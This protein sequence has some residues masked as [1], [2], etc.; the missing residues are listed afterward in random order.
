MRTVSLGDYAKLIR[1]ITFKPTEKCA[2]TAEDAVVCMRTKNVQATLDDSDL[3]AVKRNLIRNEDKILMSGDILVSSA[4][5]WNLVGKCCQVPE[6]HYLCT[7]GGFISILRSTNGELESNYLY[8]WFSSDGVQQTLRSFGNQTTNISNLDHKRTLRLQIPLPPLAE[9]QRIAA[10]LDAADALR[11]KRRE[12]LEQ[13]DALV[14]S[15]FINMFGDPVE[16]TMGWKVSTLPQIST[17]FTDGPFGSNLKSSHY[18]DE[19]IRVIRLQNIGIGEMLHDDLAFISREHY[20]SLTRNH[21]QPGDIV[22][23]TLG[24]PNLRACI[25]PDALKESLNKADCLLMRVDPD[26]ADRQYVCSLLNCEA[27]V[28]KSLALVRGQTR[29]RISLG[30]L[31]ELTVPL[32]PL[33]LQLRFAA[34]VESIEAQKAS[35]LAHLTELD[36]LFASLQSRAFN[37]EL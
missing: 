17:K 16:N 14:Q 7:A 11:A 27:I 30:R 10:I 24:D 13:L 23:G 37:G 19:G 35:Q 29:G 34:T 2:L 25:V 36:T 31:K 20:D 8:R 6:L 28:N 15:T 9:Q 22:I 5:S 32:P 26:Q 3:I 18:V 4:N 1:G 12:S 33:I 21:C